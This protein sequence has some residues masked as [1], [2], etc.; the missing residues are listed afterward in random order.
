MTKK[1]NWSGLMFEQTLLDV[2]VTP[3][4]GAQCTQGN[5]MSQIYFCYFFFGLTLPPYTQF[6]DLGVRPAPQGA[7]RLRGKEVVFLKQS[8]RGSNPGP[9]ASD[10]DALSTPPTP[11]GL[12]DPS[13]HWGNSL[14]FRSYQ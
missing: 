9:Q 10:E 7:F 3:T 1:V 14:L 12:D 4:L 6:R 8:G 11:D 5:Y 2:R 13:L